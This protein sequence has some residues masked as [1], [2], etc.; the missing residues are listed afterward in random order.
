M[1]ITVGICTW[2]RARLLDQTLEAMAALAIPA[3]VDWEVLV[4]N[5]NCTDD[6]DEV[7]AHHAQ[8]LPL[9]RLV[10]PTPGKSY[11]LNRGTRE[12]RGEWI[13]W[14]D[15]D[16]LVDRHWVAEYVRAV[17]RWPGAGFFGG[18]ITPWFEGEPPAWLATVWPRVE[19]A[20]ATR[21]LGDEPFPLREAAP[22]GADLAVRTDC[23]R[24]YEYDPTLGPR[25]GSGLRGEETTLLDAM[26]KDGIEGWWV[27]NAVVRHY[28]P[29]SRQTVRF[30]REFYGGQGEFAA[31]AGRWSIADAPQW[32]GKPRWAL[33]KAIESELKYRVRR[34]LCRPETWLED[35]VSSSL[36][37]GY[38]R[39]CPSG[40]GAA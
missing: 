2:N 18:T 31:K 29:R 38:L 17:E 8:R 14:T 10:E 16:V 12:A 25:P 15:D 37:W 35:L 39:A 26:L 19:T 30:L 3:G 4:V 6:T 9:R 27:P 21:K 36:M 33:R 11:A 23:Q 5:N 20:F 40:P 7:L 24:K 34:V 28:V 32:F 22:F 1:R 13:L